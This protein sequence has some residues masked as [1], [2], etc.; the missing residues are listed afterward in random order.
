MKKLFTLTITILLAQGIY[1]QG[2]TAKSYIEQTQVGIKLGTAIGY[3]FPCNV[4]IGGFHQEPAKFIDNQELPYRFY[5][6]KF[7]G[8]YLNLPLKHYDFI[9]F[10]LNIRTGVT[11]G[12]NFAI[13]PTLQGYV[14]PI[15]AVKLGLGLGT[16]MFQP[17]LQASISIKISKFQ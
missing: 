2:I 3:I 6:K 4:E 16:R 5:E 8:M 17:T 14:N 10:D 9:G 11:N 15:P 7:T 1:A 12:Q 13:T